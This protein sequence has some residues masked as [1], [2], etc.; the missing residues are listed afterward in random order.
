MGLARPTWGSKRGTVAVTAAPGRSYLSGE[1]AESMEVS[2]M[3]RRVSLPVGLLA[4]GGLAISL[5]VQS[6][7]STAEMNPCAP[8]QVNPC[9][10]EPINPCTAKIPNP[11]AAKTVNPCAAKSINPCEAKTT[12][13]C[14][15][16]R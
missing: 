16:K 3:F 14:Q 15:P 12:N 10:S 5:L 2:A 8:Q 9:G 1:K 13:P 4:A 6:V 11:C 7:E